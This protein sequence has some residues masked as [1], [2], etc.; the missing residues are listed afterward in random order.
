MDALVKGLL[1]GSIPTIV[2]VG[3]THYLVKGFKVSRPVVYW[4]S[5]A[6]AAGLTYAVV[7]GKIKVPFMNAETFE[8]RRNLSYNEVL[9]MLERQEAKKEERKRDKERRAKERKEL[10]EELEKEGLSKEEIKQYLKDL[11]WERRH[12]A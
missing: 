5:L 2:I 6:V 3:G 9:A 11:A 12:G 4:G 10:K 7:E 1:Q 8:A